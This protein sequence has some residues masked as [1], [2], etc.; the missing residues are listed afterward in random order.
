M[1]EQIK[2]R[3]GSYSLMEK[4][5]LKCFFRIST[6]NIKF[7]F[8]KLVSEY[9]RVFVIYEIEQILDIVYKLWI[10][11]RDNCLLIITE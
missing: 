1:H 5:I 10:E 7:V 8:W 6:S 3:V 2:L 4:E 11:S 9:I